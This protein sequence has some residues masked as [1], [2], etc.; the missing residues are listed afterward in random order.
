MRFDLILLFSSKDKIVVSCKKFFE[1]MRIYGIFS[2]GQGLRDEGDGEAETCQRHK[3][4][5][6]YL[7]W[8]VQTSRNYI[9]NHTHTYMHF[10]YN[11]IYV[12]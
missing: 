2:I 11:K 5:F 1:S 12:F 4:H 10:H 3:K 9:H 6:F 8:A 7:T